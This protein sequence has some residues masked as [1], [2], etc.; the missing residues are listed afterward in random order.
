MGD[1]KQELLGHRDEPN[2]LVIS[3]LLK[4][5][6]MP[7]IGGSVAYTTV[8]SVTGYSKLRGGGQSDPE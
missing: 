5:Y 7:S 8:H 1:R 4:K 2:H 3:S 6:T